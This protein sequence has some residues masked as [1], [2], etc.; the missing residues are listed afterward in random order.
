LGC[1]KLVIDWLI[2]LLISDRPDYHHPV[3]PDEC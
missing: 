1:R 2:H 3:P